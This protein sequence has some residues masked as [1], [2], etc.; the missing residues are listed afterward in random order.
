MEP[1]DDQRRK[2]ADKG[3]PTELIEPM[4]RLWKRR[5]RMN[6]RILPKDAYMIAALLQFADRNPGLTEQHHALLHDFANQL[7]ELVA[8]IEP[9]MEPYLMLGWNPDHDQPRHN[10]EES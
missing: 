5:E 8:N 1:T 6:I 4:A 9:I 10:G 7:I 2:L 3:F